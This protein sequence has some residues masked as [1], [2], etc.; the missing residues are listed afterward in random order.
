[1]TP[2]LLEYLAR[3]LPLCEIQFRCGGPARFRELQ[4]D[5]I[6][7]TAYETGRKKKYGRGSGHP[8]TLRQRG[9]TDSE[10]RSMLRMSNPFAV[11]GTPDKINDN[12]R[13]IRP[14][15][16][17]T[18]IRELYATS[19]PPALTVDEILEQYPSQVKRDSVT[20]AIG[21][22]RNPKYA[23]GK[24]LDIVCDSDGRYRLRV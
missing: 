15:S 5:P 7:R 13:P 23:G 3:F 16:L 2:T 17:K 18:F 24:S 11:V 8:K 20:V 4:K 21:D 9:F 6:F 19:P 22:L 1:M 12:P 14:P 10:H